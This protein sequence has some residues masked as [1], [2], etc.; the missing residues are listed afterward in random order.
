MRPGD[1]V[2]VSFLAGK[3]ASLGDCPEIQPVS[4]GSNIYRRREGKMRL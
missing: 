4:E 1:G 2:I 3:C